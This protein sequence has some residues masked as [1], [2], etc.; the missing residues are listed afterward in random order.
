MYLLERLREALRDRIARSLPGDSMAGVLVALAIGDQQAI[1]APQWVVFTRTGVNHLMSISGLHITMLAGLAFAAV[2]WLWRRSSALASRLA[3]QRAGAL[4]GLAVAVAYAA[5][6]GFGVPAQR[7]VYMLCVMALALLL[8]VRVLALEVLAAAL[9]MVLLLD[10]W[11]CL[12]AGFWLSFGAVGVILYVSQGRI[13]RP[14]W[15]AGWAQVQWAITLGLTPILMVLFQQVSLVSPLANA[16]AIPLVSLGVVPLTLLGALSPFDLPLAAAAWL[17]N[18]CQALLVLLS[19]LPGAIWQQHAPPAWAAVAAMAGV[20]WV[21]APRGVPARWLGGLAMIPLFTSQP[22][23]PQAGELWL[24]VLDVGQGHAAV[25]RTAGHALLFDSGPRYSS[26]SDSGA[27]IVVPY[28]RGSGVVQLDRILVSHN[29]TDHSGGL[30]SV[31]QAVP[32]GGVATSLPLDEPALALAERAQRCVR[33]ESWEWDGVR[34]AIL[35]PSDESYRLPGLRD[36]D[37][38]CVL[39]ARARGGAVLLSADIERESEEQLLSYLPADAA[40]DV[41]L[42][43]HHG[44]ATSSSEAFV[45]RLRPRHAVVAVGYRNRFG[46]PVPEVLS[47]YE[48]VGARVWRTDRDGAVLIRIGREVSVQAWR[49]LRPRYWHVR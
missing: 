9:L 27:R 31:L 23:G 12:S 4:A 17:M 32:A 22:A 19:S 35:H 34:F 6:A 42:V 15:L 28:L 45:S 10:P 18:A 49:A 24:D 33:G 46:H 48:A 43:P 1:A 41:L 29:D 38:S 47:R 40:V 14:G 5:L 30:L 44:S 25:L 8:G 26:D 13:G 3:A 7:T 11:A 16:V 39:E 20:V 37:R 36:N 21:L 2:S